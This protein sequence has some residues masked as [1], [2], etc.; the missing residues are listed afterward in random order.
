M[1]A[2]ANTL[3]QRRVVLAAIAVAGLIA[4]GPASAQAVLPGKN[5]LIAY[6]GA[7][8]VAIYTPASANG[9]WVIKPDG[10][11]ARPLKLSANEFAG[12]ATWPRW[13][14]DGRTIAFDYW[15]GLG[16]DTR[17]TRVMDADGGNE[18]TLF[19]RRDLYSPL[20]SPDASLFLARTSRALFVTDTAGRRS[21]VIA[22]DAFYGAWAPDCSKVAYT[23]DDGGKLQLVGPKRRPRTLIAP[24]RGTVLWSLAWAPD[25]RRLVYVVW[26][27]RATS[28]RMV[29]ADGSGD[30]LLAA[31][32]DQPAWS[33]DGKQIVFFNSLTGVLELIRVDG[34]K[35]RPLTYT[36]HGYYTA[37]PDWQPVD[38]KLPRARICKRW[39]PDRVDRAARAG[40]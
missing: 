33:P 13:A 39:L 23:A 22:T 15:E 26:D 36:S 34:S 16:S 35:R 2:T 10:M 24:R 40:N 17:T 28:L 19:A 12:S 3:W 29:N 18:R 31:N 25:G 5:G 14:P 9:I 4:G 38:A 8:T 30:H 1:L 7:R 21:R 6:W 32:G 37:Y 11:G 20:W 27:D